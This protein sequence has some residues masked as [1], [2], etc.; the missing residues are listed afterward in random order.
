MTEEQKEKV[1]LYS[2]DD[3]AVAWN[4]WSK[5]YNEVPKRIA[6][7]DGEVL[8]FCAS[9]F[10]KEI[11][12]WDNENNFTEEIPHC[13][14]TDDIEFILKYAP[15]SA[16]RGK[17]TP[18]DILR[19][20][21]DGENFGEAWVLKA[22]IAK[23]INAPADVLRALVENEDVYLRMFLAENQNAPADVLEKLAKDEYLGI[24]VGVAK[25]KNTPADVLRKLAENE[26]TMLRTFVAKN[27]NTPEDVLQKMIAN[28][29]SKAVKNAAQKTLLKL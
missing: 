1:G 16:A 11:I 4:F 29:K 12:W 26:N 5:K 14:A 6:F 13:N 24:K 7:K 25:N 2:D 9:N 19:S 8:A 28:D 18:S 17:K 22:H 27:K 3:L 15:I 21:I 23:N 10:K 20:F